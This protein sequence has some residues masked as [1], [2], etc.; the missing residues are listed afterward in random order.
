M[1]LAKM[2]I[3][4]GLDANKATLFVQSDVLEI[5]QLSWLMTCNT[6][7]DELKNMT[8][9]KEKGAKGIKMDN[10][11][12]MIPTGLFVYPPLMQLIF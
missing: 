2:L 6:S 10:N 1:N 4:C 5:T 12:K 8:Q 11:T 3:A 9:F 7:M